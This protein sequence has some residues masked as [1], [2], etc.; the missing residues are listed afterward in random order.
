MLVKYTPYGYLGNVALIHVRISIATQRILY[1]KKLYSFTNFL[2]EIGGLFNSFLIFGK[3]LV[4]FVHDTTMLTHI[5]E[6]IF[7]VNEKPSRSKK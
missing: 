3:I 6:K 5:I 2:S 7:L 1:V 4:Y